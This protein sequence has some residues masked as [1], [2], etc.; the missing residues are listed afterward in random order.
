M[1]GPTTTRKCPHF[2]LLFLFVSTV[3]AD[4]K[5]FNVRQLTNGGDHS[6]PKFSPDGK[7]VYFTA[8]GGPYESSCLH[9]YRLDL[10]T[11]AQP[12][13]L[14]STGIGEEFGAAIDDQTSF[15][16]TTLTAVQYVKRGVQLG[17]HK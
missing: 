15:E 13:S 6:F 3:N 10:H 1:S 8:S 17:L 16:V 9:V 5:L 12:V 4:S 7:A 11:P 2:L 14:I